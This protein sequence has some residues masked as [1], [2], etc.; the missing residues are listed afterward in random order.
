MSGT[1]PPNQT[2]EQVW[3]REQ[4]DDGDAFGVWCNGE[5]PAGQG[6]LGRCSGWMAGWAT[7]T[8]A[9]P[10]GS[11]RRALLPGGPLLPSA[12]PPLIT[13][14]R[15]SGGLTDRDGRVEVQLRSSPTWGSLSLV[16]TSL[17]W[18][19]SEDDH[20][21]SRASVQAADRV[22]AIACRQLGFAS[23]VA[24]G[25]VYRAPPTALLENV[26]GGGRF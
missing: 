11:R 26:S 14:V 15:L 4:C 18:S 20:P 1:V 8:A 19:L 22:A 6:R 10:G 23:G 3:R 2:Q 5:D 12:G 21:F 13:A 7:P 25:D 24:Q 16:M 9:L 17:G